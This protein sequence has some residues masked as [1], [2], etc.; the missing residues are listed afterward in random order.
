[1]TP[2]VWLILLSVLCAVAGYVIWLRE[3]PLRLRAL[4][5]ILA[6]FALVLC[7]VFHDVIALRQATSVDHDGDARPHKTQP[8][9]HAAAS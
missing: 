9:G 1:M 3:G 5:G 6:F 7:F 4:L 8:A 2:D